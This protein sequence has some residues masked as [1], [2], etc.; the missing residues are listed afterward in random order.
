MT[1]SL[2]KSENGRD[3]ITPIMFKKNYNLPKNNFIYFS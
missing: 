3:S 1:P 2:L